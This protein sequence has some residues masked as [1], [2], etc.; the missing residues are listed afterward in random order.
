MLQSTQVQQWLSWDKSDSSKIKAMS[1]DQLNK[2]FAGRMAFGTAGLRSTMGPGPSQMNDLTIIQTTQGL[3]K[4]AE[5]KFGLKKLQ[6]Q[7]IVVGYDAR[8]NSKNWHKILANIANIL[9]VK[10][11]CFNLTPTPF[12][13]F[14]ITKYNACLGVMITASHNPKN[15]NGYKVYWDNGVQILSD[16][17]EGISDSILQNLEPWHDICWAKDTLPDNAIECLDVVNE[18]YMKKLQNHVNF[19]NST[20]DLRIVYTPVHGVGYDAVKQAITKVFK[21]KNFSATPEQYL[22]DPEFPTVI[23]PNPEEGKGVLLLSFKEADR[24]GSDLVLASDPDADRLAVATRKSGNDWHVFS[25]NELGALLGYWAFKMY[26]KNN[27][28]GDLSNCYMLSS[29]VSSMILKTIAKREGFQ[30]EDTLTGFK[31]MGNRA[32]DLKTQGRQVLFAFE[33]AIGFMYGDYVLDKDGVSA[34]GVFAEMASEIQKENKT[35][36]DQLNYIY[37]TYGYHVGTASYFLSY[38][39]QQTKAMFDVIQ[40]NYPTN[41]GEFEISGI[42]DLQKGLDTRNADK[43]A[44]LPTQ[45]AHMITFYF[46]NGAILTLRTSGTEPKIKYYIEMIADSREKVQSELLK[47]EETMVKEWIKPEKYGFIARKVE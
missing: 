45:S 4:Y 12:T 43:K 23:F 34:A 26:V 2:I 14:A 11:Y 19:D 35:L 37:D 47:L 18:E 21:F 7:G 17:A 3:L 10:V 22:P 41:L 42:R 38:N 24:V 15:D 33:E 9:N 29:T 25:G 39:K 32:F 30:F 40:N 16:N 6:E 44:D 36:I 1:E 13:P 27:P 46:T 20:S 31:F 28:D 5:S 8:Y